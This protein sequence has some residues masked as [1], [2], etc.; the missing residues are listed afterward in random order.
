MTFTS[1]IKIFSKICLYFE[2]KLEFFKK[3]QYELISINTSLK[4]KILEYFIKREKRGPGY[5][6]FIGLK[7]LS[8]IDQW[9]T[10]I[11]T[12]NGTLNKA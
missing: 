4:K 2:Y 5:R 3:E 9:G 6:F 10:D 8:L 11:I 1:P 7:L 12:N